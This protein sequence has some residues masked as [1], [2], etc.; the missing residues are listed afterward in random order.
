MQPLQANAG[1]LLAVGNQAGA[2][3]VATL[4]LENKGLNSMRQNVPGPLAV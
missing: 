1:F 4:L 3:A 2:E